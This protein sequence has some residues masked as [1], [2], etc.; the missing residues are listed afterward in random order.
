[1]VPCKGMDDTDAPVGSQSKKKATTQA[2]R[3]ATSK[4][5]GKAPIASQSKHKGES[6][7]NYW[8]STKE[9][10]TKEENH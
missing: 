7:S 1:K 2:A 3:S 10:N 8:W 9:D 6:T 5:K 4:D